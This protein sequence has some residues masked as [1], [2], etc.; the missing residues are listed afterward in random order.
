LKKQIR[1]LT[2]IKHPVGGIRTYLRYTYG[3]LD[4]EKYHFTIITTRQMEAAQIKEDLRGFD[5]NLIEC[6]Q[7]DIYFAYFLF[8]LLLKERINVIHSQGASCCLLVSTL[9]MFF[10]LPH[11]VTFHETFDEN[12]IRGQFITLKRKIMS[13]LFSQADILNMVGQ[14][15][16]DNFL[17]YFPEIK[18]CEEKVVVIPN[19]IDAEL[20]KEKLDHLKCLME[21][22]GIEKG[23]FVIGYFGRF[24]PEKGFPVL[25]DALEILNQSPASI[26]N[27][28][29]LAF[30]WGAF[31]REYKAIIKDKKIDK[32][33]IFCGFQNDICWVLRQINLLVIPSL[34]EAFGLIAVEGLVTG[35]PIVA[36]DCVGLR[37]VLR[38]TPATLVK[39]GNA[40]ALASAIL[41]RMEN[42]EKQQATEF[43]SKAAQRFD[44][45]IT[46]RR[47][48]ELFEKLRK[49]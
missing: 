48:E 9:N 26:Q 6:N 23:S 38:G 27:L 21:M 3:K 1:V 16:R 25:I 7:F 30:G 13:Y 34:R 49:K 44:S 24:M 33:F 15:A 47:L 4:K 11:I 28:K 2:V 8:K 40:V 5:L 19:G 29:I 12:T 42:P 37:E 31:I 46:A 39:S 14:D 41:A 20:F 17:S 43:I 10:R 36:S 32:Y 22:P 35:T 45:C 18:K